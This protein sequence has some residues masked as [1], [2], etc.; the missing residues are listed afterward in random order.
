[1][2]KPLLDSFS[3]YVHLLLDAICAV[4]EES[5]IIYV[6]NGAHRVFGYPPEEL[7]GKKML[8][9]LH[10]EDLEK[11]QKSIQTVMIDKQVLDFENRYIRKDGQVV[12]LLWSTCWSEQHKMRLGVA[13]DITRIKAAEAMQQSLIAIS[14]T[15]HRTH[16]IKPL[17]QQILYHLNIHLPISAFGIVVKMPNADLW[18]TLF[19]SVGNCT[20][21]LTDDVM[22]RITGQTDIIAE[23]IDQKL[24]LLVPLLLNESGFG[25]IALSLTELD[26]SLN[27]NDRALLSFTAS[28]IGTAIERQQMLDRLQHLA[29]Y[30]TLTRLPNRELFQD[31]VQRSLLRA[32]RQDSHFALMYMDLDKFKDANDTFGHAAGDSL[33]KQAAERITHCVRETDTVVRFGGDEFVVLLDTVDDRK[34]TLAVAE[35]IRV[36]LSD[37]YEWQGHK[38]E[39]S[40]SIG[41]S[42][43]PEQG[44]QIPQLIAAADEAMYK[45]KKRGKNCIC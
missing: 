23:E 41:I 18:E 21:V 27:E 35:K 4:D 8:D 28:Q 2:D 7:I 5:R 42:L 22:N 43:F 33:L 40:V 44:E 3:E 1:M 14:D 29:L 37:P 15:A 16:G 26:Y 31:R 13:R 45:A 17:C 38:I 32:K 11:T 10:P 12:H 30:D 39:L 34:A 19:E 20:K 9:L 36:V 25:I 24:M 6:S